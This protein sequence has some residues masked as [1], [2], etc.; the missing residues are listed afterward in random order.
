M[1]TTPIRPA[2]KTVLAHGGLVPWR[3]VVEHKLTLLM[4]LQISGEPHALTLMVKLARVTQRPVLHH[5]L[6]STVPEIGVHGVLVLP[7]VVAELRLVLTLLRLRPPMVEQPV[8]RQM[9][10]LNHKAVILSLV[11]L[12]WIVSARGRHV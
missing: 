8:R 4:F 7:V 2:C 3:V 1:V 11:A 12:L 10:R 6:R 9:D 5:Q